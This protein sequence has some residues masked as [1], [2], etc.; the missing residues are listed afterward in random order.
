MDIFH[1]STKTG[2]VICSIK[3]CSLLS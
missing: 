1:T 2:A 3:F